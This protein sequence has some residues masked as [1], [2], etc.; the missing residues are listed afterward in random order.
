MSYDDRLPVSTHSRPK[1]AGAQRQPAQSLSK[2]STHSRPKAAGYHRC[3]RCFHS[4]VSTHSRPKAAG[5]KK[6]I[7]EDKVHRFNS[8]PPEGGWLEMIA[9]KIARI[10]FQLTAARRRLDG[11]RAGLSREDKVSTHSRPKA[12][13]IL[14]VVGAH[15]PTCFNSQPPEGGWGG[16]ARLM[17]MAGSFNSQ[18]PEGG[19]Q[20]VYVSI[21]GCGRFNS[22]PPEGG[23]GSPAQIDSV[24]SWFQLTAARRRLDGV[25]PASVILRKFQLTA[26]RRR[27]GVK[28][29]RGLSA[30]AVSTHSRPKAAGGSKVPDYVAELVST[31]SRPKA[32]GPSSLAR[33]QIPLG[34]NS[35]P[36]EGGWMAIWPQT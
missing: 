16:T 27:L 12:A 17:W 31:H 30:S 21:R 36:P 4:S 26:A 18:P 19:W 22:Q 28:M 20:Y 11:R 34:F 5:R 3:P 7:G 15:E 25:L 29:L 23:W 2:V 35:Q 13:G 32:A 8:Q 10:L 24:S 6:V 1:A 14:G 9:H 33:E